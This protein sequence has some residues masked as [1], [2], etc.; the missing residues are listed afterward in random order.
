[1]A[2]SQEEVGTHEEL[3]RRGGACTALRSG[4]VA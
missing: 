2:S 1:M 3:L 4:Q